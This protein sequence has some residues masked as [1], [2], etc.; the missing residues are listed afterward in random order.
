MSSAVPSVAHIQVSPREEGISDAF[1]L[2]DGQKHMTP[3]AAAVFFGKR[4][5]SSH[6]R[7]QYTHRGEWKAS[8]VRS[9]DLFWDHQFEIKSR[10][11]IVSS[12][13]LS[14]HP[15]FA[16]AFKDVITTCDH[17]SD[18]NFEMRTP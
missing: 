18:M 3:F 13:Q 8:E 10:N 4:R 12:S 1:L 15:I 7:K 17:S 2:Q 5:L 9:A 16:G 14:K 11:Y 6:V